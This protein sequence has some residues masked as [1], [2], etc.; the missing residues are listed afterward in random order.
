[1]SSAKFSVKFC[2]LLDASFASLAEVKTLHF[3]VCFTSKADIERVF[4][5]VRFVP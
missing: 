4:A 1:M 5:H 3:D 2:A